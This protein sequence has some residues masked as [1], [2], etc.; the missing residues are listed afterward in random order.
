VSEGVDFDRA[1]N[2]CLD[3][4]RAGEG[5]DDCLARNPSNAERL[6][7]LL[8]TATILQAPD[9]PNMSLD[10]FSV[11]EARVLAR[12]AQLR[13][14]RGNQLGSARRRSVPVLLAG[15]R[16]LVVAA[17]AGV[18]LL[19]VVLSAGTVSAASASLPGNPLYPVKRA[20][21]AFVSSAAPTPQLQARAHL[22]WADRRL[23]E[24]ETLVARDGVTDE[25]LLAALEQETDRAL[26]A[27]EQAG[28]ELLTVAVIH[29]EHQ[30]MV[31]G[32]VLEKAPS[33]AHPGLERALEASARGHARARSALEHATGPGLP[34]TPP[35]QAGDKNPPNKKQGTPSAEDTSGTPSVPSEATD[36][37][38]PPGQ[39][40]GQG[41]G[42]NQSEAED[43][44]RGQGRGQ[45]QG[46]DEVKE[47][48]HGQGRGQGKPGESNHGQGLAK[49]SEKDG[50]G[51]P[52]KG[53]WGIGPAPG[54]GSE[55]GDSDGKHDKSDKPGNSK[56]KN[57]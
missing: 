1:L 40:R 47:P 48:N 23:R 9:G 13:H 32:R 35:G 21:E 56:D 7:P 19:C 49:E 28:V 25:A 34:I 22:A 46:Q 14:R 57:K 29:T 52:D 4:L 24:I 16:R 31:L 12:A 36:E 18:L 42:H 50:P 26:G 45:G 8:R 17:V 15:P 10:G 20:T 41:Q 37:I 55:W 30:Q 11:G 44:N 43:P 53:K 39:G 2:T 33:A 27:A 54:K 6:A 38:H 5:L 3:R 51:A